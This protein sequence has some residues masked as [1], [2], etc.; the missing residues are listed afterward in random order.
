VGGVRRAF[1]QKKAQPGHVQNLTLFTLNW[2]ITTPATG[3]VAVSLTEFTFGVRNRTRIQ[4]SSSV[5]SSSVELVKSGFLQFQN[6]KTLLAIQ[7][8]LK[9]MSLALVYL[10][11][12][13]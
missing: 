1:G 7:L 9:F 10:D 12:A 6:I 11:I 5:L 8:G 2:L 4:L 13:I 3:T